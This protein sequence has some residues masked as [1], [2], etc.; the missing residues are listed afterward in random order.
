MLHEHPALSWPL[1]R[2]ML[3]RMCGRYVLKTTGRELRNALQLAEEPRFHARYNLAPTQAA[4]IVLNQSP[5]IAEIARWGLLPT[6]AR[7]TKIGT[8]LINAR[9]ETLAERPI[10]KAVLVRNQRCLIPC[11]GFYE[12]RR[13]G[14]LKLPHYISPAS[15]GILTIAGLY[16]RWTSPEG[17]AVITFT[18]ITTA[19]NADLQAIHHR[20]PVFLEGD[21]REM[22]LREEAIDVASV[23]QPLPAGR[24]QMFQVDQKVNAARNDDPTCMEPKA[25]PQV[26]LA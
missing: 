1:Q 21:L 10:Y 2:A 14:K 23:L 7:D 18:V 6:W 17:V 5:R 12:W 4:P 20:M 22:W 11:D 25:G 19:A 3:E 9:A 15:G 26:P 13:D 24:L 16:S 8:K